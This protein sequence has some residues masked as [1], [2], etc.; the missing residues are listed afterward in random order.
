MSKYSIEIDKNCSR[1]EIFLNN[2][3]LIRKVM[4]KNKYCCDCDVV[5]CDVLNKVQNKM[6]NDNQFLRI[7]KYF[8]ALGDGT[9]IR[10]VW[11]L[12]NSEMCV[13]DLSN[14]LSMSKSAI[15]HQLRELKI[16]NLIK[17]KRSGKNIYYSLYDKHVKSFVQNALEHIME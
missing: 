17:A 14:L 12:F 11:A 2:Y 6:L 5:H 9:R 1:K 7:K 13:C 10:I 8:K 3:K 15:S 16:N 4:S